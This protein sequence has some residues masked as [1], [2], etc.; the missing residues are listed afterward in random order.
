MSPAPYVK[1][2]PSAL[3]IYEPIAIIQSIFNFHILIVMSGSFK[4]Q[5]EVF[6]L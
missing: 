5:Y 2:S 4:L 6:P 3:G 1:R